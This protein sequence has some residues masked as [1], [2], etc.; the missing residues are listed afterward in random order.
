[1]NFLR[2]LPPLTALK[3]FEAVARNSSVSKAA[4]ELSVTSAAVSQQIKILETYFGR[5]LFRRMARG[6][7][8]T[9]EAREFLIEVSKALDGLVSASERM[10][11]VHHVGSVRISVLPSLATRWLAPRIGRFNFR[12][13]NIRLTI[14]SE[15]T[16]VD[17]SRSDFDL[18]IRLG[19]GTYP[20]LRV[21]KLMDETLY[22]VCAPRLFG[23]TGLKE[24]ADLVNHCLIHEVV[25]PSHPSVEPWLN[26]EPW[27][28]SWGISPESCANRIAMTD[29]AAILDAVQEGC[30]IA[31][32]RSGLMGRQFESGE[33]V[34]LFGA[35]RLS[36]LSYFVV[37][38][39]GLAELAT[40]T[41]VREWLLDEAE[42]G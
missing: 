28:G 17:F 31:I 41:A 7:A 26:W 8:P 1:M 37:S 30:G 33:L 36:G 11:K 18:A 27:L 22:P 4:D 24:P 32:G 40:V 16:P 14:V 39:P 13:P 19:S 42:Q 3:A 5:A 38:P 29:S 23:E 34:T 21:D 6:L 15:M 12:F 10:R 25:A 35:S 9:E 2:K 20:G